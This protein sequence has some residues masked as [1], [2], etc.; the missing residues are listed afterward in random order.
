MQRTPW[1]HWP[2]AIVAVLWTLAGA[3][4]YVMVQYG[5]DAY[6]SNFTPDQIDYYA[7]LPV[8]VDSLWAIGAWGALLGSVMML[9][10][11]TRTA[12]VLGL[13]VFAMMIAAIW[14]LAGAT[15]SLWVIAGGQAATLLILSIAFLVAIYLYSRSMHKVGVL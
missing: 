15:P 8:W 1:Y 13:S 14:L 9:F 12:L 7:N 11:A 3:A 4:D 2:I 5:V 6:L 10:R